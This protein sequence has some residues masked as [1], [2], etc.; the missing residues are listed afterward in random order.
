MA[1]VPAG[2]DLMVARYKDG[3]TQGDD[4]GFG[5]YTES[6]EF[7]TTVGADLSA[8]A[9]NRM[10][11]ADGAGSDP[12]FEDMNKKPLTSTGNESPESVGS[13]KMTGAD[14]DPMFD[15]DPHGAVND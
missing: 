15:N 13:Q 9:T 1:S 7:G 8:D 10:G 4:K 11:S 12:M 3:V 2:G 5:S 6:T 14:S